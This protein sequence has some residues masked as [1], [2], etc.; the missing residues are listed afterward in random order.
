MGTP[1]DTL[2]NAPDTCV[3]PPWQRFIMSKYYLALCLWCVYQFYSLAK[4]LVVFRGRTSEGD[5]QQFCATVDWLLRALKI[6][7]CYFLATIKSSWLWALVFLVLV[8]LPPA[9]RV[10]LHGDENE[11]EDNDCGFK[12]FDP[13]S[14]VHCGLQ[15]GPYCRETPCFIGKVL[16]WCSMVVIVMCL[17]HLIYCG[18]FRAFKYAGIDD[19]D[20]DH[21]W[22]S[23]DIIALLY[24]IGGCLLVV[25]LKD[26][27][28]LKQDG[29]KLT[30][31]IGNFGVSFYFQLAVATDSDVKGSN[32]VIDDHPDLCNELPWQ[33]FLTDEHIHAFFF[34]LV[35]QFYT[36]AEA[37]MVFFPAASPKGAK[38]FKATIDLGQ[39]ALSAYFFIHLAKFTDTSLWVFLLLLLLAVPAALQ[40]FLARTRKE[41]LQRGIS[42]ARERRDQ[43]ALQNAADVEDVD[44][45]RDYL[46]QKNRGAPAPV[47]HVQV[48]AQ[49][50]HLYRLLLADYTGLS[51]DDSVACFVIS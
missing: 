17:N 3:D 45:Q 8:V 39:T 13:T 25:L 41:R 12:D 31:V 33:R 22:Q 21:L 38:S 14:L 47:H 35:Y 27:L 30:D 34:Y 16:F 48:Q 46:R 19:H 5:T 50:D 15:R 36:L 42:S 37:Y 20:V 23:N 11:E 26:E 51:L 28:T 43:R 9:L 6:Y 29:A 40:Y 18:T 32:L 2:F 49:A 4:A 24:N 7:F 10:R 44:F 1:N